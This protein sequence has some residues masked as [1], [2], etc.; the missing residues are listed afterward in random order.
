M[1]DLTDLKEDQRPSAPPIAGVTD[2]QRA[3]GQ[4]LA[5]IH[6]YHLREMAQVRALMEV[7]ETNRSA[8]QALS[9]AVD[10]MTMTG[11]LRAFGT[12]CGRECQQLSFH[13]RA[14][15]GDL[16]PAVER[17]GGTPFLALVAKLR[18]EHEVV[19][20]LVDE[21]AAG[22]RALIANPDDAHYAA[23]RD[24]FLRLEAVVKS[25]FRYEETELEEVLG[26]MMKA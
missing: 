21:L 10:T 7:I 2:A 15:D 23:V 24:T 14:E 25:H 8:A 1:P 17:M 6:Q 20:A 3:Q 16:F 26:V 13:H 19:H 9:E 11:N 5:A 18:A 22:A 12:L 4:H